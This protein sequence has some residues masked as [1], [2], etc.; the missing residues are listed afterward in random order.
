MRTPEALASPP[1][2]G[3]MVLRKV[4]PNARVGDQVF[5]V[6]HE[7]IMTGDIEAGHR[8]R[9][10]EV[11]E[12]LG[13]SVMPVREAIRRLEE[14]GLVEAVPYRGAEVKGFTLKELLHIYGVRRPLEVEGARRGAE[15][16]TAGTLERMAAE[17][18]AMR[19]AIDQRRVVEYLDRDEEFL[20]ALYSASGNPVL[21]ETIQTLWRRCRAY[22]LVGAQ[23]AFDDGWVSQ[24][25]L[26]QERILIGLRAC[27]VDSVESAN[28]D[29]LESAIERI[30]NGLPHA[31]SPMQAER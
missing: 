25:S 30:R 4:E 14:I 21:V 1:Y 8:L 29:A 19:A 27:D 20:T 17:Y 11:A 6:I 22:K 23:K 16:M 26:H 5:D 18:E 7:A 3:R 13:T 9:I 31:Q 24:L 10:R 28:R 2:N 15:E 12:E